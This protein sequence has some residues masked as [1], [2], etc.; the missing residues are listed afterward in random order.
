MSERT[1]NVLTTTPIPLGR[2]GQGDTG[3]RSEAK[4]V[5]KK[6]WGEDVFRFVLISHLATLFDWQ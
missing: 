3:L 1:C 6:G 4:S 2:L 5:K